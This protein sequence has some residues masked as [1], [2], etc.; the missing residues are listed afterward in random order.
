MTAFQIVLACFFVASLLAV[1]G[2]NIVKLVRKLTAKTS[3]P[4]VLPSIA[5]GLVDDIKSVTQLRDRLAA[6]GC[7]EGVEACTVLLRVIVE[8]QEPAKGAV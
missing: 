4:A 1:Y 3:A 8:Y 2:Q 7:R 6:E 5:I